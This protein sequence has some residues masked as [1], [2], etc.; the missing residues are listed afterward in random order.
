LLS[1]TRTLGQTVGIAVLGALWASRV[2]TYTGG[3]LPGGAISAPAAAQVSALQD[4]VLV[5]AALVAVALGLSIWALVEARRPP[6]PSTRP[7]PAV[8]TGT[9]GEIS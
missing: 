1:L 3:T 5:S 8:A 6:R 4:T 7:S 9:L 2:S